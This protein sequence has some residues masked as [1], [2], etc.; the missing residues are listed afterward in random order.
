MEG[1]RH[2]RCILLFKVLIC[3]EN[4]PQQKP[5]TNQVPDAHLTSLP[6]CKETHVLFHPFKHWYALWFFQGLRW[7]FGQIMKDSG[8]THEVEIAPGTPP[9][10]LCGQL[11][12]RDSIS[13]QKTRIYC[14]WCKISCTK[15]EYTYYYHIYIYIRIKS[16]LKIG[17]NDLPTG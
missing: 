15:M 4:I 3:E 9:S 13:G 6:S 2:F 10:F 7:Y 16:P 1:W 5:G 8:P 11:V 12:S 17:M 14:C